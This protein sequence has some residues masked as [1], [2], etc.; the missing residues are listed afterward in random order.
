MSLPIWVFWT[1]FLAMIMALPGV[2][3]PFFPDLFLIWL[4]ALIY[5][6]AEG[7]SSVGPLTLVA[8]MLLAGLGFSAELWMSQIGAKFGGAS[9][10]SVVVGLLTGVLGATL[11]LLF[12]GIGIGPGALLGAL[13]GLVLTEWYQRRDWERTIKVVAGWLVGYVLS[14]AAQLAIG[15]VMILIFSWQVL[16][17]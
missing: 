5:A 13:T 8:L 15:V 9:N 6:V 16:F 4:V 3:L 11:G 1:A 7:F 2:F 12:L 14:V 10:W 17:T